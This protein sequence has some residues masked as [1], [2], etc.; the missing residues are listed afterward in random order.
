M[1]EVKIKLL[2]SGTDPNRVKVK[3]LREFLFNRFLLA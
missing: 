2:D 3:F 1:I